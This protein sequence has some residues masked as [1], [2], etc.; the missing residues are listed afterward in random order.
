[1]KIDDNQPNNK[2]SAMVYLLARRM[3]ITELLMEI[4]DNHLDTGHQIKGLIN[5]HLDEI[6]ERL[7]DYE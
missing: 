4:Y 1:M 3:A 2:Q 5:T 6:T 7:E